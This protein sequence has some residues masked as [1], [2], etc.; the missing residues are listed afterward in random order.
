MR[1]RHLE[2]SA[3]PLLD[4]FWVFGV[5]LALSLLLSMGLQKLDVRRLVS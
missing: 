4:I 2:L 3:Y 5:A 1:N